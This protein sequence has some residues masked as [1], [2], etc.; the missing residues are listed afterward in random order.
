M[1]TGQNLAF[2]GRLKEHCVLTHICSSFSLKE[3][4]T[5]V[6]L[7]INQFALLYKSE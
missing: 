6:N 4:T 7:V 1:T 3:L 2:R 5:I